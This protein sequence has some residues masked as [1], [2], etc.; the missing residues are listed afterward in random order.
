MPR[1]FCNTAFNTQDHR[2][3]QEKHSHSKD[4]LLFTG[5]SKA[6]LR[7]YKIF[8]IFVGFSSSRILQLK[9]QVNLSVNTRP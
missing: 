5:I 6:S 7:R 4:L 1:F 2:V 3:T 8:I 9:S